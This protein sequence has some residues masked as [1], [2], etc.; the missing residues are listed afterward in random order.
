MESETKEKYA[1]G[2]W[3]AKDGQIYLE[4]TGKTLAIIP[5]FD[6]E[7]EQE[8]NANLMALAPELLKDVY[9]LEEV[10]KK[11]L[12]EV[13]KAGAISMFGASKKLVLRAKQTL[14]NTERSYY[15][16]CNGIKNV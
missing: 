13:R 11:L 15:E 8:A 4:E 1:K 16:L 12:V 3:I 9:E 6:K 10:C 2:T 14:L 7:E 5:Y